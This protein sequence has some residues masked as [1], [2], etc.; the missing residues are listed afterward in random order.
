MAEYS[1]DNRFPFHTGNKSVAIY[2]DDNE[3][4]YELDFIFSKVIEKFPALDPKPF[5][6]GIEEIQ[7]MRER[8]RLKCLKEATDK[9]L[10]SIK[11][12]LMDE[13]FVH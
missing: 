2:T 5:Y 1:E 12:C 10:K 11:Y 7:A 8:D 4:M 9:L 6:K 3:D 13:A